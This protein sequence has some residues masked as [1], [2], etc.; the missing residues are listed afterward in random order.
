MRSVADAASDTLRVRVEVANPS[1]RPA[2]EH[3]TVSF[4]LAEKAGNESK[5][6]G[7]VPEEPKGKE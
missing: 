2:G 3:V 4:P 6:V 7:T 5:D 1:L